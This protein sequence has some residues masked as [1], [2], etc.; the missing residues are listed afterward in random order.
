MSVYSIPNAIVRG[1][2]VIHDS[3][4]HPAGT[5][6][7]IAGIIAN[8]SNIGMAQVADTITPAI[9]YQYLRAFGLG[10]YTGLNLPGESAGI[11]APPSAWAGDERYTLAYGQ[12]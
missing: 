8:S 10:Q 1:G 5:R 6:Y 2:Q 7:T 12:G 11:L 3:E 4:W 9:Q